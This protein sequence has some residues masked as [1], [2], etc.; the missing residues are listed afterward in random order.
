MD[1]KNILETL[2]EK[3]KFFDNGSEEEYGK[4]WDT[5]KDMEYNTFG[6]YMLDEQGNCVGE[7][8]EE[9]FIDVFA[10]K[11]MPRQQFIDQCLD[12][13]FKK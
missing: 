7:Y 12:G 3:L 5:I 13:T 1:Y 8:T 11:F 2:E 6:C 9:Q 4:L 10:V